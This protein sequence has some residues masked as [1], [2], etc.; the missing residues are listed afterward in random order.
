MQKRNISATAGLFIHAMRMIVHMYQACGCV[1]GG[2]T[3]NICI[4][5]SKQVCM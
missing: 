4:H 5:V 3:N 1:C 2:C